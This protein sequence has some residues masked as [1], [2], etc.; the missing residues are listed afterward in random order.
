MSWATILEKR[1]IDGKP[2]RVRVFH[3]LITRFEWWSGSL[4]IAQFMQKRRKNVFSL[5]L[6]EA[7]NE[8]QLNEK[9]KKIEK[10]P[11]EREKNFNGIL[12][13]QKWIIWWWIFLATVFRYCQMMNEYKQLI[14]EKWFHRSGKK[15]ERWVFCVWQIDNVLL[16]SALGWHKPADIHRGMFSGVLWQG[17]RNTKLSTDV[18]KFRKRGWFIHRRFQVSPIYFDQFMM[19]FNE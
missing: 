19:Q 9:K 7:L 15:W 16:F 10:V 1:S 11:S 8:R 5:L 17:F 3:P 18:A 12:C 4:T 6:W 13:E 14:G 2:F